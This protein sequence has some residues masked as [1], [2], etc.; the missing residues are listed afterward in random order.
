MKKVCLFLSFSVCV[1]VLFSACGSG[2]G[3]S[4]PKNDIIGNVPSIV[5]EYNAAV[6]K[7]DAEGDKVLKKLEGN[8]DENAWMKAM[9][10][11][12]EKEKAIEAKKNDALNKEFEKIAGNTIP[13]IN[14]NDLYEVSQLEI[15]YVNTV[16]VGFKGTITLKEPY[17]ESAIKCE[18]QDKDGNVIQDISGFFNFTKI[19]RDD[20]AAAG[21]YEFKVY[22][23]LKNK[24]EVTNLAQIVIF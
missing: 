2:G 5:A 6:E 15:D 14:K 3:S 21:D 23:D 17:G 8:T 16:Q 18:F 13:T 1:M 24:P 4:L 11:H 10:E 7:L 12:S 9:K 22:L 19:W 20:K